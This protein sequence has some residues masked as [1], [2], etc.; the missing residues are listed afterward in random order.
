MIIHEKNERA[1]EKLGGADDDTPV[2][3][4]INVMVWDTKP[5]AVTPKDTFDRASDRRNE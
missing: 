4:M 3:L 2:I 5:S 1:S